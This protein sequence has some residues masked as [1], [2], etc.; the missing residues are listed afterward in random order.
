MSVCFELPQESENSLAIKLRE[1]IFDKIKNCKDEKE[2]TQTLL[3]VLKDNDD[4]LDI[5]KIQESQEVSRLL[6]NFVVCAIEN[7]PDNLDS[8]QI[9]LGSLLKNAV[10]LVCNPPTF[11]I[12]Y[13]YPT[14]DITGDFTNKLLLALLRLA[15][16]IILSIIKKLLS[17]ISEICGSGLSNLNSYGFANIGSIIANSIGEEVSQSFVGD[18]FRSFGIDAN[19]HSLIVETV[20]EEIPCEDNDRQA[21]SI[22]KD[23]NKFLD[24]L[25]MMAT[26]VELCSLLNNKASET[27][28]Q[29]VEELLKFEYPEIQKRLN[30]RTKIASLFATLGNRVDPS[31]CQIIEDNADV[32]QS[33]PEICF[34]N[35]IMTV[36]ENL[37]KERKLTDQQIKDVINQERQRVIKDLQKLAELSTA[38]KTNPDSI[39]GEPPDIFCKGKKPGLVNMNDMPS[40]KE[41]INSSL[42]SIFN[43]VAYVF[44]LNSS[45][46]PNN[47]IQTSVKINQND[48][49]IKKFIDSTIID[50]NGDIQIIENSLNTKFMQ[51]VAS[52]QFALCDENGNIDKESLINYYED[53]KVNNINVVNND[54]GVI[55]T[56][57]LI[58]TTNYN[59]FDGGDVYIVNYDYENKVSP[60]TTNIINKIEDYLSLD[61][62]NLLIDIKIPNKFVPTKDVSNTGNFN[63]LPSTQTISIYTISSGSST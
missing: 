15:I 13:P 63:T 3:N 30:N 25:S 51:R 7:S 2:I 53:I 18:V 59:A 19:G 31:I 42:D 37:L 8:T 54:T 10:D 61:Y 21:A 29:V 56:Q 45:N 9:Q 16:K 26:P 36:R 17:L 4:V 32:I 14:V 55:D 34:T 1:Q 50:N 20:G 58:N 47:I 23:I 39:L 40:L 22:I 57:T 60:D 12:P 62:E 28:F 46:F 49:V 44:N 48:K 41:S 5:E 6:D 35:D 52:G 33:A 38:I 43:T 27:T 24:D 11:S